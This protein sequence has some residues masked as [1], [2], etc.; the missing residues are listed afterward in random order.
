MEYVVTCLTD[1]GE[2]VRVTR[3]TF[4]SDDAD[5]YMKG[6]AQSR[7]PQKH[8][9]CTFCKKEWRTYTATIEK[10]GYSDWPRCINCQAC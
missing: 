8:S 3:K 9:L 2:R 5:H 7:E 4:T 1:D 10:D 6:V